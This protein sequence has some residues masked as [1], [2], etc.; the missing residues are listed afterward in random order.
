MRKYIG[1]V[2]S[3]CVSS[4]SA[5]ALCEIT[6]PSDLFNEIRKNHPKIIQNIRSIEQ[7]EKSIEHLKSWTNPEF[8]VEATKGKES[9][10]KIKTMSASLVQPIEINGK[11]K[12][13]YDLGR[14]Q[15]KKE[16]L[17]L[18]RASEE[19]VIEAAL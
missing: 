15:I 18:E 7:K 3:L 1:L 11:K 13:N 9:E 10:G 19:I 5:F 12:A 2:M 14:I 4:T 8:S 6:N 16:S 17:S